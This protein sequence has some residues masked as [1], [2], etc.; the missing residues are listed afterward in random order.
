MRRH[1]LIAFTLCS[2]A[3]CAGTR[4]ILPSVGNAESTTT[5]TDSVPITKVVCLW[6]PGAG[7]VP[8]GPSRGVLG[9]LM[10]F[11]GSDRSPQ[12]VRGTVT[13]YM[14]DNHG[15]T[16]QQSKPVL[17]LVLTPQE[18]AA[19]HSESILGHAYNIPVPYPK[20]HRL[21]TTCTMRVKYTSPSGNVAYSDHGE[22][23]P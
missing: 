3:G 11:S 13:I 17:K 15:S 22:C 5:I 7:R 1:V 2:F 8:E 9:Q 18:L 21:E 4:S 12:E 16:E 14:F 19:V 20:K 10:F 23:H 6:E